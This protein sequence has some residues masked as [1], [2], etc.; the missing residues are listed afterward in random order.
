MLHTFMLFMANGQGGSGGMVSLLFMAAIFAV[1]YLF[2]IRPQTKRQ[3][4]IQQKISGLKKGDKVVTNGG[5]VG[6]VNNID[7]DSLLVEVDTNV[8]VR[9]MK[10]SIVDVN[11]QKK[12]DKKS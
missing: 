7:D 2:I 12:N 1:F 9:F 4:D 8:K 10:N 3:K 11:P 6:T 5:I